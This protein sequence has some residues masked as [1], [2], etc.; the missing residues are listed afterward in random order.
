MPTDSERGR[1]RNRGLLT[2]DDRAVF[3]GERDV[4]ADRLADIR[5]NV[6]QRMDHIEEDIRILKDAGEEDLVARFY[7]AFGRTGQLEQRIQELE[8]RLDDR[9]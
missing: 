4:D 1:M 8:R 9:E 3:R 5:Y 7:N 2:K 6:R